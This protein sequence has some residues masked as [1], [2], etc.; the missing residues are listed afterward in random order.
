MIQSLPSL[1]PQYVSNHLTTDTRKIGD[2]EF[3]I[4]LRLAPFDA[5]FVIAHAQYIDFQ[6]SWAGGFAELFNA[7]TRFHGKTATRARFGARSSS[8]TPEPL[9]PRRSG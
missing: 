3:I 9:G 2:Q 6:R 1:S 7:L 4:P 5:P 8:S